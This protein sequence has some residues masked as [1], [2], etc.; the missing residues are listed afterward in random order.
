MNI[1]Y[2]LIY[3]VFEYGDQ[4]AELYSSLDL[5]NDVKSVFNVF[6]FLESLRFLVM[7]PNIEEDF[8]IICKMCLLKERFDSNIIPRSQKSLGNAK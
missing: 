6:W 1:F 7:K 2:V 4:T 8:L 5:T 3:C